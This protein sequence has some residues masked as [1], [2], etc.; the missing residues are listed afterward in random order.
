MKT[1]LVTFFSILCLV[2]SGQKPDAE[3]FKGKVKSAVEM[4]YTAKDSANAPR[5]SASYYEKTLWYFDALE[6]L[7]RKVTYNGK[8]IT[9]QALYAS[10]DSAE[11]KHSTVDVSGKLSSLKL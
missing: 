4:S 2:V 3:G 9:M 8:N 10:S 1:I 5:K 7:Y 11:I 6:N